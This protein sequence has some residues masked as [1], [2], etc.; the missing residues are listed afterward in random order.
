[1]GAAGKRFIAITDPGSR[2]EAL[3]REQG[4]WRVFP[5][6]KTIGG[7]YSVLS[8]FGVVPAAIIG[9]DVEAIFK[10]AGPMV[11]ACGPSAPPKDNPAFGLG[12][13]MGVAAKSGRDK[14]TLSASRGISE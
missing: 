11:R 14:I 2:L 8:N 9:L 3:A 7:R 13:L 4:F 6:W 5:G 12:V 1:R 10:A